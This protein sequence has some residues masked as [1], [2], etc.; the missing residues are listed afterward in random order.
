M[1]FGS[2]FF[3]YGGVTVDRVL[4]RMRAGESEE[5]VSKDFGVPLEY[6]KDVRSASI[7]LAA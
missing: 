7:K 1:S 6:V 5:N 2:P 4:S 3:R